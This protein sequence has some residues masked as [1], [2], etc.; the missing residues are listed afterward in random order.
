MDWGRHFRKL[1]A[2]YGWT[3]GLIMNMTA[4]Q[5]FAWAKRGLDNV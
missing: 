3:P 4:R 1:S 2:A 5:T